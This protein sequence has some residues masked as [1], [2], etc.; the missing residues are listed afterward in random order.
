ME[1]TSFDLNPLGNMVF[2]RDQQITMGGGVV[3]GRMNSPQRA[4]EVEVMRLVWEY[5][6]AHI[7]TR[8]PEGERLEGGDYFP[9]G[10]VEL[11]GVGLRTT[12]GAAMHLLETKAFTAPTVAVVVD[13]NDKN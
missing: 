13:E 9:F 10:D 2:A 7:V 6:G 4:P 3:L 5:L 1:A 12:R 11:L 8:I